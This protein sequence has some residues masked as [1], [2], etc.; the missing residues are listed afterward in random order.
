MASFANIYTHRKVADT[1]SKACDICYKPSTSVLVSPENKDFFFVCPA[2]LKDKGFCNPI[3][4]PAAVAEKKKEEMEAE[5]QR[6]KKEFEEKQKKKKE[7]EKEKESAK[8]TDKD[9]DKDK[10]DK[11][12]DEK[13]AEEK[14]EEKKLEI[15]A[16]A[17]KDDEPRVFA[18]QKTFYQQRIDKKRNAEIA[19]RNRERLQNPNLFPQV[20]KGL[21]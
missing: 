15:A 2:H 14:P 20:P 6:V 7:K 11:K 5:I 1:A 16:P 13:A 9:K 8:N 10:K 4:N 17:S 19:K 12:D 18:L 21:P 3:I